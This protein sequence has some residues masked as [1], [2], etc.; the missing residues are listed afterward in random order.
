MASVAL[1][2]ERAG[3]LSFLCLLPQDLWR[4]SACRTGCTIG[5]LGRS[6][7][8]KHSYGCPPSARLAVPPR[9]REG[10][11]TEPRAGA[12]PWPRERVV[13]PHCS[14]I[15]LF[16]GGCRRC[17]LV[18]VLLNSRCSDHGANVD[19][20]PTP[21]CCLTAST[22]PSTQISVIWQPS[23]VKNAAPIHSIS[24]PVAGVPKKGPRWVPRKRIRAAARL[25][26]SIKSSMTH[27]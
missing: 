24:L 10:P 16:F 14:H 23:V 3:L 1:S 11:L 20:V 15:L 4:R 6:R 12:Q 9:P 25:S 5:R 8:P 22:S 17:C 2:E 21:S 13:M 26:V 7:G 27:R 18:P 19:V